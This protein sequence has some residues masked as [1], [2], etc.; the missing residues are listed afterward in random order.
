MKYLVAVILLFST[1]SSYAKRIDCEH[2]AFLLSTTILNHISKQL[3]YAEFI[4]DQNL[5]D[6]NSFGVFQSIINKRNS[7]KRSVE[8]FPDIESPR[9]I[10]KKR[11]KRSCP[12]FKSIFH[13]SFMSGLN[14]LESKEFLSKRT[15]PKT[16]NQLLAGNA[17]Q[18][19]KTKDKSAYF[20]FTGYQD[21]IDYLNNA[22]IKVDTQSEMVLSKLKGEIKSKENKLKKA[23]AQNDEL[24]KH[25]KNEE[26]LKK[27]EYAEEKRLALLKE[28]QKKAKNNIKRGSGF[29]KSESLYCYSDNYFDL[30]M[31]LLAQNILT[32]SE[33]CFT[34]SGH[35][36]VILEDIQMFSGECVLIRVHDRK[37]IWST[38]ESYESY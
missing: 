18:R 4:D 7:I 37:K 30:Q 26:R 13:R 5:S 16:I 1:Q 33:G 24:A 20:G 28:R 14:R 10:G 23:K 32:I 29:L 11:L 2:E 6:I 31:S 34:S 19:E 9:R 36:D 35:E 27:Q 38:C 25:V 3:E 8:R 21:F 17:L 22:V 12:E 15:S